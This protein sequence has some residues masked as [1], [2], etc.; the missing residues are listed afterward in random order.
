MS[1]SPQGFTTVRVPRELV[2]QLKELA[3]KN[4]RSI[5]GEAT[6]ALERYIEDNAHLIGGAPVAS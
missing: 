6:F 2:T 5:N 3:T 4:H 1:T